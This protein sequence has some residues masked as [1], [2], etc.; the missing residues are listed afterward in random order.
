MQE[1]LGEP[2]LHIGLPAIEEAI[3]ALGR[4]D[5]GVLVEDGREGT[6]AVTFSRGAHTHTV[7]IPLDALKTHAGAHA[8]VDLALLAFNKRIAQEA[9]SKASQ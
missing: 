9:V 5:I 4:N 8:A 1:F 6:L 3:V 2:A 7:R